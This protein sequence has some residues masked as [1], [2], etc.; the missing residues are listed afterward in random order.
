MG[1][2]IGIIESIW[3]ILEGLSFAF[4]VKLKIIIFT[5]HFLGFLVH[6]WFYDWVL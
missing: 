5:I 6:I 1:W 2:K 3:K 4:I